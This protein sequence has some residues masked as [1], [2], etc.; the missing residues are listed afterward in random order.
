MLLKSTERSEAMTKQELQLYLITEI[1]E[2]KCD[3]KE[4]RL[5]KLATLL[6]VSDSID[7]TTDTGKQ[8]IHLLDS[9]NDI[10][11]VIGIVPKD[12]TFYKIP[13]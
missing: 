8:M 2:N 5:L 3:T 4:D 6:A 9:V 7:R 11:Q 12:Q 10:M 13:Q 1:I